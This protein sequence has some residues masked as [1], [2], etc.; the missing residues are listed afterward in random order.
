[1]AMREEPGWLCRA[2]PAGRAKKRDQAFR[3]IREVMREAEL[4]RVHAA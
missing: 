4:M 2:S 3:P 1:M